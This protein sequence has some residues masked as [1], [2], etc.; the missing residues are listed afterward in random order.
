M[1]GSC[2][3][4]EMDSDSWPYFACVG[5]SESNSLFSLPGKG[6]GVC[7]EVQCIENGPVRGP[8]V[9]VPLSQPCRLGLLTLSWPYFAV[10]RM[11]RP[12]CCTCWVRLQTTLLSCW[13]CCW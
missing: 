13:V 5:I 11:L 10:L 2:G 3:Y 7:V 6:C 1:Q 4:G 8:D 9:P 12:L